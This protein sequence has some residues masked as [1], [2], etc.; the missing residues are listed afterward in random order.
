MA[1]MICT[2]GSWP[3]TGS[4]YVTFTCMHINMATAKSTRRIGKEVPFDGKGADIPHTVPAAVGPRLQI[5]VQG[6]RL[7]RPLHKG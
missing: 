4:E 5:Q 3:E 2:A 6:Q 7:S 1:Y